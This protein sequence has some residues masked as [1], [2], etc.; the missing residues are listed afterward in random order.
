MRWDEVGAPTFVRHRLAGRTVH[1]AAHRRFRRLV[2]GRLARR[3]PHGAYRPLDRSSP[4]PTC[5]PD[6]RYCSQ[7]EA[8]RQHRGRPDARSTTTDDRR[9]RPRAVDA[10]GYQRRVDAR[11]GAVHERHQLHV[12]LGRLSRCRGRQRHAAAVES[13]DVVDPLVAIFR[14]V[15]ARRGWKG[16]ARARPQRSAGSPRCRGRRRTWSCPRASMSHPLWNH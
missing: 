10:V 8:D 14:Q 2:P 4:Q 11:A 12:G 9:D 7:R 15:L 1:E 13:R 5:S 6:R 3:D 16:S